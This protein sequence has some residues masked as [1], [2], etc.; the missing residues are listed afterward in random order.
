M[1][2]DRHVAEA[3]MAVVAVVVAVVR[4]RLVLASGGYQNREVAG[5]C[6]SEENARVRGGNSVLGLA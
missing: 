2:A 4:L 6:R 1:L 5:R 3:V